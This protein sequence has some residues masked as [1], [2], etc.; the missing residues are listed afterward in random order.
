VPNYFQ[1]SWVLGAQINQK[2]REPISP[3]LFNMDLY[4][5]SFCL[6]YRQKITLLIISEVEHLSPHLLA[7][8]AFTSVNCMATIQGILFSFDKDVFSF[9]EV[10][11]LY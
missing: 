9:C 4:S 11:F 8:S 7:I 10:S 2:M 3:S 5:F 6:I 1:K